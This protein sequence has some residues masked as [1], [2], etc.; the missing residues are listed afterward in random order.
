MIEANDMIEQISKLID[1]YRSWLHGSI[2]LRLI[3]RTVEITTPFLDRHND[4]IQIYVHKAGDDRFL[5]TDEGETIYD[6]E[7]SGVSLNTPKRKNQLKVTTAGFGVK[8]E[9]KA[10]SVIASSQKFPLALHKIIQAMLAINDLH[11]TARIS[12]NQEA[13][14]DSQVLARV[15][16]QS[17]LPDIFVSDVGD[18]L[19]V[20]DYVI[21]RDTFYSGKFIGEFKFDYIVLYPFFWVFISGKKATVSSVQKRGPSR[22]FAM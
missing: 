22:R 17:T 1:E 5:L 18:W 19:A 6:L 4:C 14:F 11:Y 12:I 3:G 10:I 7:M 2:T 15:V 16:E 13:I 9:N 8:V 20:E 21:Q